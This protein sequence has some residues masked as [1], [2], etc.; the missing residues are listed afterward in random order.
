M[1]MIIGLDTGVMGR[2]S[3]KGKNGRDCEFWTLSSGEGGV[4]K[5]H[6]IGVR[7]ILMIFH[8]PSTAGILRNGKIRRQCPWQI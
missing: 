3:Q 1:L 2:K 4:R 6:G 5:W 8:P 7:V